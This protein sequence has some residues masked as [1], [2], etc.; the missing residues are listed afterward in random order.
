[1]Y[2]SPGWSAQRRP[3]HKPRRHSEDQPAAAVA[4]A[5]STKAGAQ[6]PA[7]RARG[8]RSVA[9]IQSAQRRPGH[10]PRRH[11]SRSPV[12]GKSGTALNEGRGTNPGDTRTRAERCRPIPA[13]NEGRGTN[14]GDTR[15]PGR[16]TPRG[17]ALNEGRGTNP[18]DTRPST[19][20]GTSRATL[21]EGRGTNPGDTCCR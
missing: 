2:R 5:R 19:R 21:N 12:V 4:I 14:P 17:P 3:G 20:G 7:T 8:A 13:L 10:K 16:R 9:R 15:R 1:M 11:P 6:T 18:G